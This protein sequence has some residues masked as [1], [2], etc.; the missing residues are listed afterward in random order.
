MKAYQ[1]WQ[2]EQKSLNEDLICHE[3]IKENCRIQGNK[4]HSEDADTM[5][6]TGSDHLCIC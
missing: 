5:Q 6:L 4:Q 3:D 1:K 2:K